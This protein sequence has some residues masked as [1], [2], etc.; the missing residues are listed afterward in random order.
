MPC[1]NTVYPILDRRMVVGV[2]RPGE[3]TPVVPVVRGCD[4][5]DIIREFLL[6]THENLAQ[7]DL[8][9]ITLEQA[10]TEAETLARVF[11]TLHTV[12]GTAGFLGLTKLQGLTHAGEGLLSR[13][14]A[15]ELVFNPEIA[16]A[17]LGVVDAIRKMLAALE[18]TEQ[19]GDG[20]YSALIQTLER[21]A[22]SARSAPEPGVPLRPIPVSP[23]VGGRENGPRSMDF[24]IG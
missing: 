10:P 20:D 7:A 17:L 23:G 16:S 5:N 6:E 4:M 14:R 2:A 12:K 3:N 1:K 9:L 21:L 11:R 15:R 13:L 8:D 18:A 19:E 24:A 22:R